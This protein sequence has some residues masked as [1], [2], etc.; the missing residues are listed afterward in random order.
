MLS[1]IPGDV[2]EMG[3]S[4]QIDFSEIWIEAQMGI[5]ESVCIVK[6]NF[7]LEIQG[8]CQFMAAT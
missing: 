2:S 4:L 3:Y 6:L 7:S 5:A 1:C 8:Y